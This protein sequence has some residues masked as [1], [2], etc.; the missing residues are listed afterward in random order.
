[1]CRICIRNSWDD[2]LG[3]G[4]AAFLA[5]FLFSAPVAA[6]PAEVENIPSDRY[7]EVALNEIQQAKSSLRLTMYLVD[8]PSKG[9]G[10]KVRRL[11]DGLVEAAGRGVE[12]RVVL[13][14]NA[15]WIE[16]DDIRPRREGFRSVSLSAEIFRWERGREGCF[17][18][19]RRGVYQDA[20]REV[21]GRL[22]DRYRLISFTFRKNKD[23]VILLKAMGEEFV[24]VP[25]A[26][27]IA[28]IQ[29]IGDGLEQR[30]LTAKPSHSTL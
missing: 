4:T 11:L 7:F 23:P 17:E 19:E 9:T 26:Y 2:V 1:M 29:S 13:D 22:Q 18:S 16:A 20:V 28:T 15:A 24:E 12:V 30:N 27:L 5:A 14:R 25:A 10:S 8:L 21:L 6:H 3:N